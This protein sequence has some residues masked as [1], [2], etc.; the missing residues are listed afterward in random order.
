MNTP[1]SLSQTLSLKTYTLAVE[2]DGVDAAEL[3]VEHERDAHD[4]GAPCCAAEEIAER[5]SA[6]LLHCVRVCVCAFVC[7]V[8]VCV[9]VCV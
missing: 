8:C 4:H 9:C 6:C 3:L 2:H 7:V 5:C 1:L